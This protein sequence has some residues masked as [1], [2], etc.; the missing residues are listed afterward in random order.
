MVTNNLCTF[1]TEKMICMKAE[2][3]VFVYKTTPSVANLRK[4]IMNHVEHEDNVRVLQHLYVMIEQM[5]DKENAATKRNLASLR[6]ILKS[7]KTN[8]TYKE[9]RDEHMMEKYAL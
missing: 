1:A 4:L 6:G 9:M 8:K 7:D 2:E 5:K 3:P